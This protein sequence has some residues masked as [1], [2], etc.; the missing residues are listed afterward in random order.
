[1]ISKVATV[2]EPNIPHQLGKLLEKLPKTELHLHIGGSTCKSDLEIFMQENGVPQDEI[3]KLMQLI[4]LDYES[5]TDILNA[6]YKV[7][8]HVYT[9]SQFHRAT[10][11]IIKEAAKDNV[12]VFE[13]RTSILNK[14]GK[15]LEIVEAVEAGIKEGTDWVRE[16]FGYDMKVYLGI[17]A[18]RFDT[19]EKSLQTAKLAVEFAD[20][21]GS[22]IHSFDLAGDESKHSIEV[23]EEALLYIK[24]HGPEHNIGLTI[25]AGETKSSGEISGVESIK[26]AIEYGADRLAHALRLMDDDE[27]KKFVIENEIPVEMAPWSH[28]QIKAVDSYPE[29][30]IGKWLN[31]GMKIN[32]STDNR[33]MS[34]ITLRLQ[35]AQLWAN[36]LITKWEQ[37][38]KLTTNGIEDA[39]ISQEEKEIILRAAKEEFAE[40]EGRFEKTITRYLL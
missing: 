8:K 21:P 28:V 13:P 7:P 36:K 5:I 38:K 12:K 26:K 11:G 19:P 20:R 35:L 34:Q 24:E 22:M 29:H 1:M 17:L 9:P 27:L 16:N 31:E 10:V 18:Q 25:H 40:L 37:L 14:G 15:P 3:P 30:P 33:L 2:R 23:H 6:Y 4:K 39:F 32:L